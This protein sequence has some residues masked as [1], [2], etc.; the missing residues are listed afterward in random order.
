MTTRRLKREEGKDSL[1]DGD[2]CRYEPVDWARAGS[3]A[4]LRLASSAKEMNTDAS[5]R[6]APRHRKITDPLVLE[7]EH[8]DG[9][10]EGVHKQWTFL[11]NLGDRSWV[12][13]N[14]LP[15]GQGY[16]RF[17]AVYGN[18]ATAPW[19]LEVRLDGVDGPLVGQVTLGQTDRVRGQLVQ[20]FGEA[21]AE[22]S[23]AATGMHDVFL[24]LRAEKGEPTVN[25]EYLRFE[26]SR[27]VIPLAK[28]EVQ[29]EVRVGRRDGPKIGVFY[30]RYTGERPGEFVAP[31]E[32]VQGNQPLFLGRAVGVRETNRHDRRAGAG[33]GGSG[34]NRAASAKRP[35]R[36]AT[37]A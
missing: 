19:R 4:V 24:V 34:A 6:A 3:T 17:R 35:G 29:L 9:I 11:Y 10:A 26:Q 22:L 13:F 16:R 37:G 14:Q 31:L 28:N 2:G 5:A 33:K 21:V 8:N 36:T 18:N 7:M 12:R 1:Q 27:G 30:P 32:P 23:A 25:F 15:L 20:I